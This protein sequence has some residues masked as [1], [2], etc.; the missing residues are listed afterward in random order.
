MLRH[1][2]R[3]NSLRKC[4]YFWSLLLKKDEFLLEE[5]KRRAPMLIEGMESP[6]QKMIVKEFD[7]FNLA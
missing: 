7:L 5:I 2:T 4:V 6:S 1:T 3:D